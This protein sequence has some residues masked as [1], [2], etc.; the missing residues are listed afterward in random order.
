[1]PFLY[2]EFEYT[3]DKL[4]CSTRGENPAFSHTPLKFYTR[5]WTPLPRCESKD[6]LHGLWQ[7]WTHHEGAPSTQFLDLDEVFC[8]EFHSCH[9]QTNAAW[10]IL[11]SKILQHS[12]KSDHQSGCS[13]TYSSSW[14]LVRRKCTCP[15]HIQNLNILETNWF[16]QLEDKIQLYLTPLWK[17]TQETGQLQQCGTHVVKGGAILK[18]WLSTRLY[19]QLDIFKFKIGRVIM[20][21]FPKIKCA[22]KIYIFE[23]LNSASRVTSSGACGGLPPSTFCVVADRLKHPR[24]LKNCS[25]IAPATPAPAPGSFREPRHVQEQCGLIQRTLQP[26]KTLQQNGN[27]TW[28]NTLGRI[29]LRPPNVSQTIAM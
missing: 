3:W 26:Q 27:A 17:F 2:L 16:V 12:Q 6:F 7:V 13:H 20:F 29:F 19:L 21:F 8:D 1:M 24:I 10:G 5:N 4:V 11:S 25:C 28:R 18:V 14:L 22:G 23:I 9:L 15:S